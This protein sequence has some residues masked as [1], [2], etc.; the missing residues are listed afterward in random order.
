MTM[1]IPEILCEPCPVTVYKDWPPG[2]WPWS[3]SSYS[4]LPLVARLRTESPK[5][6][7]T[8]RLLT[9]DMRLITVSVLLALF[10][11]LGFAIPVETGTSSNPQSM[12]VVNPLPFSETNVFN[13]LTAA[14]DSPSRV[15]C[16]CL[17]PDKPICC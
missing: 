10:S 8:T 7:N 16:R 17:S 14:D 6:T 2:S 3:G 9:K 1:P 11:G 13:G 12:G 4:F 15:D 5:T